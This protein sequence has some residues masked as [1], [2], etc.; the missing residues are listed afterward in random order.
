MSMAALPLP[1]PLSHRCHDGG[2]GKAAADFL[3]NH[4]GSGAA[5]AAFFFKD[6]EKVHEFDRIL[7][8]TSA[9]L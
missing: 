3:I 8:F 6:I 1:P 7:V 2:G 4:C 9:T 5:A